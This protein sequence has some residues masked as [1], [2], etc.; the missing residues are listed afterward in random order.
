MPVLTQVF[1]LVLA[2]AVLATSILISVA[3][4]VL[5]DLPH[6]QHCLA[7]EGGFDEEGRF[8]H[9]PLSGLGQMTCKSRSR[10]L[11]QFGRSRT[12]K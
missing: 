3:G 2:A 9:V 5:L 8:V 4:E 11:R 7:L 6:H 12:A 10:L 1:A